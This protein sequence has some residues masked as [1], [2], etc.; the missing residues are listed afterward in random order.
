MDW[1]STFQK[2]I[3]F[4]EEHLTDKISV[5]DVAN[6]VAISSFYLQKSFKL[7]TDI[8]IS[9]Y[10][11][12]RRL[13]LAGD[14]LAVGDKKVI[15]IAYKYGYDTPESFSKAFF[16]FHGITPIKAKVESYRLKIF[17]PMIIHLS[18]DGGT[19]LDY[20]I[21]RKPKLTLYGVHRTFTYDSA[22]QEIPKFWDE[23][24]FPS[25]TCKSKK[26]CGMYGISL[27]QN[28]RKDSF[29]YY[30]ADTLEA[31]KVPKGFEQLVVSEALWVVFRCYGPMPYA[32]QSLNTRIFKDWLPAHPQYKVAF[33]TYVEMYTNGDINASDYY[34]EIWIPI[35]EKK[36][37]Y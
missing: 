26:L 1:I 14:E 10:L 16:R 15:D 30:I 19:T 12:S 18:I 31:E 9:D 36:P 3:D 32:L 34:S 23:M 5:D 8:T 27:D 22:H 6:E 20:V 25:E 24:I 2:A 33:G 7:L 11:K 21:E 17:K 37:I 28:E 35:Q 13:S 29:I 4:M